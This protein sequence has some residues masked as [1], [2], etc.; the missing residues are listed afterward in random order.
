VTAGDRVD[1]LGE[2]ATSLAAGGPSPATL[3]R[4]GLGLMLVAAGAHKLLD[5]QGWTVY[6]TGWL[7]PWLVVSPTTFMLAN[8]YLELGF[9]ALLLADRWTAFAAL[10]AAVSLAATTGYL[11]IVWATTGQFGDVVARDVGL[12]G[13]A[14]AVLVDA[15]REA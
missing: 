15:L 5:P 7:A 8:G 10:V 6:V 4:W 1:A 12:T 11:A 2:R 14:L 13:L 9:A 3:A